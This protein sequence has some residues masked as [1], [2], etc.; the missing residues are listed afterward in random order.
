MAGADY[1]SCQEKVCDISAVHGPKRN[2]INSFGMPLST[3]GFFPINPIS[4]ME[5]ERPTSIGNHIRML[6]LLHY[7]PLTK[8]IVSFKSSAFPLSGNFT[9]PLQGM[10]DHI[11]EIPGIFKV[12]PDGINHFPEFPFNCFAFVYGV[13]PTSIFNPPQPTTV[14]LQVKALESRE[15]SQGFMGIGWGNKP[16][17][18]IGGFAV[19]IK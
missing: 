14:I 1:P 7:I 18:L 17:R 19:K 4:R 15:F 2:L 13:H 3:T 8:H 5:V 10:V 9:H 12:I 11:G 6:P 16:D